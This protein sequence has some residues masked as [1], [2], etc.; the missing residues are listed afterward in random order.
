MHTAAV[1]TKWIASRQIQVIQHPPYWLDLTPA[2]FFLFPKVKMELA[3]L[4]LTQ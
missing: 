1:V 3:G 2:V 4:T